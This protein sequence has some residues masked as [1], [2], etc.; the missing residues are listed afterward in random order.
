MTEDE[1]GSLYC[2]VMEELKAR[3]STV[4]EIAHGVG[5]P[6]SETH[7]RWN[8]FYLEGLYLQLRKCC[9]LLAVG[10]LISQ[11]VEERLRSKSLFGVYRADKILN[12]LEAINPLCFP[13]PVGPGD[14]KAGETQLVAEYP[15]IFTAK[16]LRELYYFCDN[17]LHWGKLT[18]L[19][20]GK[21]R[22]LRQDF[23]QEWAIKLLDGLRNHKI[24]LP[25]KGRS[26][27]VQMTD[28]E[29]GHV[30]SRFATLNT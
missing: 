4:S 16:E 7:L 30:C 11:S 5:H 3:V 6:T 14:W 24:D 17:L 18:D 8:V 25:R 1:I 23:V 9:E 12:R 20:G 22:E 13:R 26:L 27:L 2:D 21:Q 19:L 28:P 15:P 29:T 10:L